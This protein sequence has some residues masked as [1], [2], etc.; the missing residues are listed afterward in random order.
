MAMDLSVKNN[1]LV[2]N[3]V[4]L[5]IVERRIASAECEKLVVTSALKNPAFVHNDDGVGVFDGGESVRNDDAGLVFHCGIHCR[6][7][8][9]LGVRVYV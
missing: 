4:E 6:V 3:K 2:R 9:R 7:E 1:P 8:K 5:R